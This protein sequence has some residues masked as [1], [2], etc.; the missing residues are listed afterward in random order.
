MNDVWVLSQIK[1]EAK[2]LVLSLISESCT[3][4]SLS[5]VCSYSPYWHSLIYSPHWEIH[6]Y[7]QLII[8]ISWNIN[9]YLKCVLIYTLFCF[10]ILFSLLLYYCPVYY[11]ISKDVG[12]DTVIDFLN[13]I[14]VYKKHWPSWFYLS[15][16]FRSQVVSSG[17][18]PDL[19]G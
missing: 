11:F 14:R 6:F 16:R 12:C 7:S 9:H 5:R 19:P 1:N 8:N 18:S 17:K 15:F 4:H 13:L 3:G 2:Y 10:L